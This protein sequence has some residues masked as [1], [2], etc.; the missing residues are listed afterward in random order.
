[1]ASLELDVMGVA[2]TF[3]KDSGEFTTT[4]PN[5]KDRFK[6]IFSGGEQSRRGTAMIIR[7]KAIESLMY[8]QTISDRIILAK[9]KGRPVDILIIQVYAPT[10]AAD[11]EEIEHFYEEL[12]NIIKT[13]KKYRDM[14]LVI[15]DY[16]AKIGE[17]RDN[18]TVGPHGLGTRNERGNRLI[19]FATKHKVFITNTWFEQKRSARH[20]WTSPDD[21]TKKQIDY[22]LASQRYRNTILNSKVYPG[23]DCSSDHNLV[24]TRLRMRMKKIKKKKPV[25]K[26][27]L[28]KITKGDK[29]QYQCKTNIALNAINQENMGDTSK[30]NKVKEQILN[31]GND[32]CGNK[33]LEHKQQWM[34]EEILEKMEQRKEQKDK[35]I[36]RYKLLDRE[37]RQECKQAKE[38]HYNHLCAEIEE[39]DKHHN[40]IMYSKVKS[41]EYK[42]KIKLGVQNKDGELLTEPEQILDRWFEYIGDLYEDERTN[43]LNHRKE[44]V[45]IMDKEIRDIIEKIQKNKATGCDQIPIEL[46]QCLGEDG[47]QVIVDLVQ[48]IYNDEELPPDF[49]NSIFIPLPKSPKAVRCEDHRTIS[50]I[51]HTAKIVLNLI[52]TRIAPIIEQQL[53]DSQYGFR[54]GRGTRDAICQLRI[55]MER[56]LEMQKTLYICFIDYT[57]AFDRVKHDMLFEILSKAGVPDKEINIIKSLYL[58]QKATVRYENET[59]E[60]IT[61]KRG[62]R[63]G[64]ILSPCLFNIYTEYLI[65]EALEDGEGININGQNITNIRYADDTIILAESEQQLQ[66]MI[67]KLS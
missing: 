5:S 36:A 27:D 45:T 6:V 40:P 37:I 58:Q 63:Q 55:M 60:E 17:G 56:C 7:N 53:S 50:L 49:V 51:S 28:T 33:K 66:N 24:V 12:D 35:D 43:T 26:L 9:Y 64:C 31:I 21:N 11:D 4:L 15:G 19:E 16:N 54:T 39:L 38:E 30:W 20:T 29:S 48:K 32:I 62:V 3:W 18:K 61:I 25:E 34:T 57:K 52:K 1:M 44:N 14:L 13:H 10:T 8:Y 23:A 47:K 2:E 65:R 46:I 59:S 41:M 42:T 22:I 67:D